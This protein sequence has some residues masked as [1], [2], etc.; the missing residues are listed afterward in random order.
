MDLR[1]LHLYDMHTHTHFSGDSE[2]MPSAMAQKACDLG[3]TGICFTDHLDID[4]KETP[5]LF[6]LDIPAYKKEI[7]QVKEQFTEK[8]DIGWGIE[9]G[10]QPYL[11]EKNA[12]V[13]AENDFDFVIGS[14]H[15]VKQIDIYFPPYYEGRKEDDCYLEYFEETLKNA[16]SDVDFDVYGHLDYVV[17]Y[18]PNKNKYYSYKKFAD[19]IDEILRTL[20]A[21]GKGIELNMAGF[22]YGLGH[23]HPTME[24]LRRYKELG[25]EI[26]TIGSDGHAPEQMAWEFEKA[27]VILKA[28]GFDYFTVFH[29]RKPE[30][31]KLP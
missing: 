12:Q 1:S 16:Q 13:I 31:I 25:G 17:R 5:G 3:L 14:T 29:N 6:D 30:F 10:L 8:L 4:Y 11:A 27:P 28:A 20:I 24:T 7:L 23:A 19:I 2:A 18:G 26:I 22:K 15:V 9:L 21:K